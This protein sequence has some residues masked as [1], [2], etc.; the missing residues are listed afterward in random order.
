MHCKLFTGMFV[1]TALHWFI[2]LPDGHIISFDQFSALFREQFI[3]NRAPPRV[4]F[5]LFGVKQK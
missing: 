5:D 3:V 4:P 1:G 2:G